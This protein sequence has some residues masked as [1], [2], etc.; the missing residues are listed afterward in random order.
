MP[1]RDFDLRARLYHKYRNCK[2]PHRQECL[3]HQGTPTLRGNQRALVD[4]ES[5]ANLV[6][7]IANKKRNHA[8]VRGGLCLQCIPFRRRAFVS[9]AATH[10]QLQHHSFP[11]AL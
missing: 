3:C 8:P 9:V 7:D 4:V 6:V 11:F 5:K 1:P 2:Q 10:H